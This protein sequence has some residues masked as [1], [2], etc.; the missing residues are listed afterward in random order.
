MAD[1]D[2]RGAG[3]VRR[4]KTRQRKKQRVGE[5]QELSFEVDLVFHAPMNGEPYDD[6]LNAFARF[7]ESRNLLAGGFGGPLPLVETGGVVARTE[8]GS[9]T[10]DDAQAVVTWLRARPDVVDAKAS[11]LFDA[12]YGYTGKAAGAGSDL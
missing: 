11:H 10:E 9:V 7:L 6:F 3:R 4:L 8:R 2:P 1:K 12:W 5:F